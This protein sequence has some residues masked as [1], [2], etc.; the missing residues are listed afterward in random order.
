MLT[1]LQKILR[2]AT[3]PRILHPIPA[4]TLIVTTTVVHLISSIDLGTS[5]LTIRAL[6]A[7]GS[8]LP[9]LAIIA[10]GH[11][12]S[13]KLLL[14]QI[15]AIIA[16]YLLAGFTRGWFLENSL[17][18]LG[19][20]STSGLGFRFFAGAVIVSFASIIISYTWSTISDARGNFK[21]LWEENVSLEETVLQLMQEKDTNEV[22]QTL[23]L[24]QRITAELTKLG[25]VDSITQRRNLEH[26]V[27]KVVRPLSHKLAPDWISNVNRKTW[28]QKADWRT[29]WSNLHPT[30]HLPSPIVSATATSISV[31]APV[32]GLYGWSTAIRL[33]G[34]LFVTLTCTMYLANPILKQVLKNA[35]P[36]WKV[37]G[38]TVGLVLIFIPATNSTTFA[39]AETPSPNAFVIA[40]LIVIPTFSWV[41]ILGNAARG[42]TAKLLDELAVTR[43]QLRWTIARLNVLSWYNRGLI[44]RLLHGPIQNS[45]QVALLEVQAS[46]DSETSARVIEGAVKRIEAAIKDVRNSDRSAWQD[47]SSM[48]SALESWRSIAEVKKFTD[49]QTEVALLN[50]PAGCAILTDIVME[51]CSNAVRHGNSTQLDIS[52][53]LVD[54][55][56]ELTVTD[57]GIWP[58]TSRESGLGTELM[59][60]CAIKLEISSKDATNEL[61]IQIPLAIA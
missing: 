11:L 24:G 27:N 33:V 3:D 34:L 37:I 54:K 1:K 48:E 15:P 9:A 41:V 18:D 13:K 40:G 39:L 31:L 10:L 29:F 61:R 25:Q 22:S 43:D 45:L 12:A 56:V 4:V 49:P 35:T 28:A 23:A 30:S 26:L 55:Q 5:N 44:S 36:S 14:P 6:L 58:S 7:A 8:F 38:I 19:L 21:A 50:D 17:R 20:I 51:A 47:L 46:D 42:Y 59:R 57:N 53:A 60:A 32:V 16:A 2:G 52:Y